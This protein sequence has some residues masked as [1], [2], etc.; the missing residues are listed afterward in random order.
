MVGPT[1][2][3]EVD[4]VAGQP[5]ARPAGVDHEVM[6]PGAAPFTFLEIELK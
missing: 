4:L 1:G 3:S 2:E 5:Y 6:N